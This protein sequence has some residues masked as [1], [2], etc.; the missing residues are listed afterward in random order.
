MC[1]FSMDCI[2]SLTD[3]NGLSQAEKGVMVVIVQKVVILELDANIN[4]MEEDIGGKM[5][6]EDVGIIAHIRNITQNCLFNN[7]NCTKLNDN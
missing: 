3:I 7:C 6:I 4:K 1:L 2:P 5:D